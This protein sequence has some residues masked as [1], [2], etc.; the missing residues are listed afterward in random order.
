MVEQTPGLRDELLAYFPEQC[1]DCHRCF[2]PVSLAAAA[3]SS[4]Q[5]DKAVARERIRR[6]ARDIEEHCLLGEQIIL[7]RPPQ[8][9]CNYPES[10]QA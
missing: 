9:T 6:Q 10:Q 4:G 7:S 2:V 5:M 1:Q 3:V 8:I